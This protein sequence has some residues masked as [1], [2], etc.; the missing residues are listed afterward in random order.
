MALRLPDQGHIT[1]T[2][3]TDPIRYHYQPIIRYFMNKRLAM[4]AELLAGRRFH[5][6]LD[7]G[8]GGGV[9]LP[10]L[11]Q[12]A[13]ELYGIDLHPHVDAVQRMAALEGVK[14]QLRQASICDTGFPDAYFDGVVSISVLEFVDDLDGAIDELARITAPGA[15][16][17]LGFPGENALTTAG[18]RLARTPD[19]K[20]VHRATYD[21]IFEAANRRFKQRR[22]VK[23][24]AF[25][26][27]RFA[28][29]FAGEFERGAT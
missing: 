16:L 27:D 18:Y 1:M 13:D 23:F 9:F 15:R 14:V 8:Y 26:P 20:R 29:F 7:A 12:M 5:R 3:E 24:P 10:E 28:L 4:G 6:L 17:V 19:P 2:G 11:A 22:V 25:A 21:D